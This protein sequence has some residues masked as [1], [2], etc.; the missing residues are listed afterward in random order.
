MKK[1]FFTLSVV[2]I[3]SIP[4]LMIFLL[5]DNIPTLMETLAISDKKDFWSLIV[6]YV[7][8]LLTAILNILLMYQ[9]SRLRELQERQ[10]TALIVKVRE[11]SSSP[12]PIKTFTSNENIAICCNAEK[13]DTASY[14][15]D[16][17]IDKVEVTPEEVKH[18]DW[19]S[20]QFKICAIFPIKNIAITE[21]YSRVINSDLKSECIICQPA[22]RNCEINNIFS[23]GESFGL[24]IPVFLRKKEKIFE[25]NII[26][27]FRLVDVA[28][29]KYSEVVNL[30]VISRNGSFTVEKCSIDIKQSG[31]FSIIEKINQVRRRRQFV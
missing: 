18:F 28:G 10:Y 7:A 22:I 14:Y 4:I 2:F 31:L 19:I 15:L 24:T 23:S 26:Y 16:V 6:S 27:C 8:I 9:S 5:S 11:V 1:L 13:S 12:S 3:A 25:T 30:T 29:H 21:I 20:L 17:P